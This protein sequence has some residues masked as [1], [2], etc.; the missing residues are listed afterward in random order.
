MSRAEVYYNQIMTSSTNVVII[1]GDTD[2]TLAVSF[3][4]WESLG[5]QRLWITTSQWD[6][7]PSLENFTFGN[8][9]GT[10]AFGQ[11]HSEISGFKHFV[12]TLDSVKCS[13]EYLVKLEWLHFNCEVPASKCKTLKNC[14]LNHSLKWLSVH[15]FDMAFIEGSYD[16]YTAVY[17]FAHTLH[18]ITFQ[19]FDNLPKDNGKEHNY[20]C[21]KV[22]FLLLNHV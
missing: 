12:Q 4:M 10:F 16:I 14:W 6:A 15:T 17:A 22:M 11:Y 13:D 8:E 3:K 1:Y 19:L 5:I 20:S 2:S 21:R 9:Y 18:W 7:S